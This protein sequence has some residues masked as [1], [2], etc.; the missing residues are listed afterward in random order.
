MQ[1]L[2][3]FF[4][5]GIPAIEI[6]IGTKTAVVFIDTGFNAQLVLPRSIIRKMKMETGPFA[7]YVTSSGETVISMTFFGRIQWFAQ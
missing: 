2:S 5:E 6:V 1:L 3:G 7:D 4:H